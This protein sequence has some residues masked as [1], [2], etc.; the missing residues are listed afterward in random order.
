M[1]ELLPPTAAILI[2]LWIG[3]GEV[4]ESFY[5][6][7]KNDQATIQIVVQVVSHVL[8]TLQIASMCDVLNLSTRFRFR[9]RSTSLNELSL[10]TALSTIRVDSNL[11]PFYLAVASAFVAATLIPGA[12][13]YL[14]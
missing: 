10:W 14:F 13:S 4:T 2:L 1:L 6:Y 3:D 9:L 12:V 8:A 11:P 7:L 5:S